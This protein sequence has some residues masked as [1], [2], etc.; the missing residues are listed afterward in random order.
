MLVSS[1]DLPDPNFNRSVVLLIDAG[2]GKGAAG[3]ILNKPTGKTLGEVL[4]SF[5]ERGE[6]RHEILFGGPVE[7]PRMTLLFRAKT[8]PEESREVLDGVLLGWNTSLLEKLLKDET[9]PRNLRFFAG[10][11]GWSPGQIENEI[12]R[13]DWRLLPGAARYVFDEDPKTLWEKLDRVGEQVPIDFRFPAD[14]PPV[15]EQGEW[16]AAHSAGWWE[17]GPSRSQA[18][19]R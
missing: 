5:A 19:D 3:L 1:A 17:S 8:K 16:L 7:T 18:S 12:A 4:P 15:R 11:A 10:Y 13:G 2:P 14:R 9:R 6:D